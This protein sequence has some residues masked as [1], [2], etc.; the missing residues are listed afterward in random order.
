MRRLSIVPLVFRL[1]RHLRPKSNLRVTNLFEENDKFFSLKS[2]SSIYFR[3][4]DP[5]EAFALEHL[6][7]IFLQHEFH[8][9]RHLNFSDS[10]RKPI[11]KR[12]NPEEKTNIFHR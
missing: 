5:F 1:N 3:H 4:W 2:F 11:D 12:T 8:L 6:P 9:D 10:D 7:D